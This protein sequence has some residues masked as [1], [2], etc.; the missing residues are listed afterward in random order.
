MILS[1]VLK[2]KTTLVDINGTTYLRLPKQF[3]ED[4]QF[5]FSINDKFVV[6]YSE[7]SLIVTRED[8]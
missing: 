5:P 6:E 2:S 7:N 8:E 3:F 4:S 1:M